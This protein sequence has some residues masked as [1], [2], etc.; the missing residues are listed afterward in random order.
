MIDVGWCCRWLLLVVVVGCCCVD[1]DVGWFAL[2]DVDVPCV[3]LFLLA[4][5]VGCLFWLL[6]I[7]AFCFGFGL[8]VVV[9]D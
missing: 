5:V 1:V 9:G 2:V 6:L 3:R 4:V 8:M 7:V